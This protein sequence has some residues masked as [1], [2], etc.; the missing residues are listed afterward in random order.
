MRTASVFFTFQLSVLASGITISHKLAGHGI[1]QFCS[2]VIADNRR[3][4]RPGMVPLAVSAA[5]VV[6]A[7][8]TTGTIEGHKPRVAG[9]TTQLRHPDVVEL[10]FHHVRWVLEVSDKRALAVDN[11]FVRLRCRC[12]NQREQNGHLLLDE[13]LWFPE[14]GLAAVV[15]V[16]DV[17]R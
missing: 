1:R 9:T 16:V 12:R 10:K 13:G 14:S 15:H 8:R 11:P 6:F 17:L 7:T 2:Q 5:G 3:R 4:H